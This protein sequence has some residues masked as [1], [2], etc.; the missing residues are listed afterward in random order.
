MLDLQIVQNSLHKVD[1]Q[2][3]GKDSC[4]SYE[5]PKVTLS[6]KKKNRKQET[7]NKKAKVLRTN[8]N[9]FSQNSD[10]LHHNVR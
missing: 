6:H 2:V 7:G 8:T 9:I 10:K 1:L 3:G 5:T 4:Q